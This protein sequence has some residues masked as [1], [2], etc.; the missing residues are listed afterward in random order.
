MLIRLSLAYFGLYL[1]TLYMLNHGHGDVLV[2]LACGGSL[3][4]S[5]VALAAIPLP[6][7]LEPED[8]SRGRLVD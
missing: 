1:L 3:I 7:R 8:T 6:E 2:K 5:L 4:L